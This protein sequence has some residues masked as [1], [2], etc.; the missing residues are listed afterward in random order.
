MKETKVENWRLLVQSLSL[1]FFLGLT[2]TLAYPLEWRGPAF[3]WLARIDPWMLFS[4][5]RWQAALPSWIWL[6]VF[7][8]AVAVLGGRI[9]CGWLCPVGSLLA[10][11]DKLSRSI[12]KRGRSA[13]R[14]I[15]RVLHPY[16][17]YLLLLLAAVFIL[18]TNW[19]LFFTPFSLLSHEIVW[20]AQG[21]MPWILIILLAGTLFFSRIWCGFFCPT[22][23][24]LSLAA[25][26]RSYGYQTG[27]DC[28]SCGKCSQVCPA[29]AAPAVPGTSS[30]WCLTCGA[31]RDICPVQAVDWT[32]LDR[33][34]G[35]AAKEA[36]IPEQEGFTRRH[37]ALMTTALAAAFWL[38]KNVAEAS[39]KFLRPPGALAEPEFSQI[40]SR[41]GRCIKVCP[42]QALW[43]LSLEEGMAVGH[44]PVF[45]PR[46]GRCDMCMACQEI[47]PTGAIAQV[48]VARVRIGKARVNKERCLAW[49]VN[50]LCFLCGEQC[51]FQAVAGDRWL[52]PTVLTDKCIGCGACENGCP[53]SGEAAIRVYVDH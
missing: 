34:G 30:E 45:I 14:W 25:R 2:L 17:Y 4:H 52:R 19:V 5:L 41:C 6:P 36:A 23:L 7:S 40:C 9:F 32:R 20:A 22:G 12:S 48:P 24:L 33:P 53:V 1:L 13:A 27:S 11:T 49:N 15:N 28:T 50:K 18:G 46:L 38:W 43:P 3:L 47:C 39:A 16:R 35:S 10:W 31:C 42:N 8:L 44:T 37:F 29:D 26:R 21:R 51:P